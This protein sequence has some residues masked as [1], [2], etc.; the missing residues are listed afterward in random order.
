[1]YS[2][3]IP[4]QR[5]VDWTET[6]EGQGAIAVVAER[7]GFRLLG[8]RR[9]ARRWLWRDL[10]AAAADDSIAVVVQ[11]EVDRY[12]ARLGELVYG[13]G[14]PRVTINLYRLVVVPRQLLNSVAHRSLAV[15]LH[16]EPS[17]TSLDCEP[18]LEFLC[19][20]IV[21]D[22][23]LAVAGVG[24][25]AKRPLPAGNGWVSVGLNTS[26]VWYTVDNVSR[27]SGYHFVFEIPREPIGRATR[28]V[29][30]QAIATLEG[31][32]PTLTQLQ[33]TEMLRRACP[34][35]LLT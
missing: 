33:R 30:A 32:L 5:F 31:W 28:R 34:V 21:E 17:L 14:L 19:R 35:D 6:R 1:M 13:E 25:W 23:D 12:L 27:W 2:G 29:M 20:R 3:R 9:A 15:R 16:S 7:V 11:D 22:L 8:K 10:A 24:P 26:F 18:L 4:R